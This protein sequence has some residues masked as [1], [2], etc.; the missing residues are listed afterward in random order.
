MKTQ[1]KKTIYLAEGAVEAI[2]KARERIAKGKYLT[3]K[4]AKA[5]LYLS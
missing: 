3:E 5:S 2:E 4:Q 1:T